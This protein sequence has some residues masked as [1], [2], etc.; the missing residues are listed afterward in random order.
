MTPS[1][2]TSA[3]DEGRFGHRDRT[4]NTQWIGGSVV[5]RV[6]PDAEEKRNISDSVGNRISTL[7]DSPVQA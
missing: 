1:I 7:P 2:S 5:P 6:S 4:P 3:L